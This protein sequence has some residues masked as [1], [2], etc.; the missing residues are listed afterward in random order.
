MSRAATAGAGLALLAAALVLLPA[1]PAAAA[2]PARIRFADFYAGETYQAAPGMT[3]SFKLTPRI[4]SL[5]GQRVEILGFMDGV[6]PR[7]GMFFMLLKEPLIGC[8]FHSMDFDWGSFAPVFLRKG[9][10]YIDGPIKVTGR[11]EVG[12]KLDE[13]GFVSYVRIYDATLTRVE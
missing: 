8:P 5:D 1:G 13:T 11:L 4:Q 10:S 6:L 2:A 9:T 12:K 7:D 3:P